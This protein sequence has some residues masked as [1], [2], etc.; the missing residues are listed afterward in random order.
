MN[1]SKFKEILNKFS[2]KEISDY[3]GDKIYDAIIEWSDSEDAY[4]KSSLIDLLVNI[5]GYGLFRDK[6]FRM[7]FFKSVPID[8]LKKALNSNLDNHEKLASKASKISFED[9]QFYR[10]M[11]SE[12]FKCPEY[13]FTDYIQ[14]NMLEE[15]THS[16]T[17][18]YELLDYQYLIKQQAIYELTKE[19]PLGRKILIHMPTGTG[20]TK[21]AMHILTHYFN[22]VDEKAFVVWV[23]HTKELLGQ[24]FETF[25][26]VWS[27]LGLRNI[28]VEKSWGQGEHSIDSGMIFTTIQSLQTMKKSNPE[29]YKTLSQKITLM[30]YDEC[31]KIGAKETSKVVADFSKTTNDSK[32]H[33]IGLTAT[34]GRTTVDSLENR[35][36]NEFFD[37]KIEI[38]IHLVDRIS[39]GKNQAINNKQLLDIIPYFQSRKI[40]SKLIKEELKYEVPDD[41]IEE[42]RKE[43]RNKNEMFSDS[44]IEKIARNKA[45]NTVILEKLKQLNAENKPTIVFACSVDH[46]KMLSAFLNI[47]NISNSLVYGD[48]LPSIREKAISDFKDKKNNV[49]IIINYDILT[50]GFDSTNIECVF[51]TRPTKS[52][53]LYSQMIGRG[54]RGPQMG[55]GESCLL[56]DVIDNLVAFDENEAFIHFD[57]YWR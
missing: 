28:S 12:F 47:E 26:S 22:F 40:L 56:I 15:I 20:K 9:N 52:V 41:L 25:S 23:A 51:I 10:L 32:K 19:T 45:R 1:Y 24:A 34:P 2:K 8:F 5:N 17:K 31:H 33:F 30:V 53:I 13:T 16:P 21:T 57:S 37:R 55:G 7:R 36:F 43:A 39:M 50:T 11:F 6:S 44:L 35:I 29:L 38:D 48:M 54:L 18:F 4:T 46:A 27:H 3:L 42:I 49:N 14:E